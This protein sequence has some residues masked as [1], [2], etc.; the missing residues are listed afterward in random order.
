MTKK[1]QLK[2]DAEELG[3]KVNGTWG[4]KRIQDEIDEKLLEDDSDIKEDGESED[5]KSKE[6]P[7]KE[8]GSET[9]GKSM[10]LVSTLK[11][12]INI[13]GLRFKGKETK[14]LTSKDIKQGGKRLDHAIKLGMLKKVKGA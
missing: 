4:E 10:I 2:L 7:P 13:N 5:D 9:K 6:T 8:T 14:K 11:N 12:P 3:I 1:E